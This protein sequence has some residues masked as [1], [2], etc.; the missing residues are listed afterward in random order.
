MSVDPSSPSSSLP[1][2]V[3]RV[4]LLVLL[5]SGQDN[6]DNNNAR[7][8]AE[9][10]SPPMPPS[11]RPRMRLPP[12]PRHQ[13]RLI[14]VTGRFVSAVDGETAPARRSTAVNDNCVN[15]DGGGGGRTAPDAASAEGEEDIGDACTAT[16]PSTATA[17]NAIPP[18]PPIPIPTS[19][20]A[21]DVTR[22][23]L[24]SPPL[25]NFLIVVSI[26]LPPTSPLHHGGGD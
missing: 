9:R 12:S 3:S 1:I 5:T 22:A 24:F 17:A 4:I 20:T 13:H 10:T 25:N 23:P 11:S 26:S 18:S 7:L 19:P 16:A 8:N 6:D 2:I 21:D 15:D 14:S